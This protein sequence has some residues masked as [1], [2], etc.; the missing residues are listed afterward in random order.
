MYACINVRGRL[1]MQII[2]HFYCIII[3]VCIHCFE[4][5][6]ML[7]HNHRTDLQIAIFMRIYHISQMDN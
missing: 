2:V 5:Y 4:L 6:G 3:V 7:M 1:R